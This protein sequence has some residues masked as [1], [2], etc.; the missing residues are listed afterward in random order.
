MKIVRA[1]EGS[2]NLSNITARMELEQGVN[3]FLQL[4]RDW[5]L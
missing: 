4:V 1:L 3:N 5:S 2:N